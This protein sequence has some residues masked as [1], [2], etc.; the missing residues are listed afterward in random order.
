[1]IL[2]IGH[3]TQ[4]ADEFVARCQHSNI[5]T[6][7]DV[8]SHPSSRWTWFNRDQMEGEDSW[9]A[10]A[11]IGY[12]WVPLLGGW[13]ERELGTTLTVHGGTGMPPG[14]D[15]VGA[16]TGKTV[17]LAHW[18]ESHDVDIETYA[19]GYFPKG[20]I[21]AKRQATDQPTWHSQGMRDFAWYTA[22]PSFQGMAE[23]LAVEAQPGYSLKGPALMCAEFVWW[24]CHRAMIADFLHWRG[25]PVTHVQ[26][27]MTAHKRAIGDRLSRYPAEVL[28]TW[29][30]R[31][32]R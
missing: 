13:S 12:R 7:I 17:R 30:E 1:M 9:L 26:P 10:K 18:A 22:L 21:S 11:N 4:T 19:K 32:T 8:R 23:S 31:K 25:W 24:K 14:P 5:R 28:A 15:A 3:S 20:H 2:T 27:T 6:I 29:G 16:Y